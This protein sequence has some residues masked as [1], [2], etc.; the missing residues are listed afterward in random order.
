MLQY[1]HW[2]VP[3]SAIMG[4]TSIILSILVPIVIPSPTIASEG[5]VG[6]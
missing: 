4:A 3:L 6:A 5:A 2:N 1:L